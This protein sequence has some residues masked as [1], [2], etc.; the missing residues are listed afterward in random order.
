MMAR[1]EPGYEPVRRERK[2]AP[3]DYQQGRALLKGNEIV[4]TSGDCTMGRNTRL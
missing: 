4:W 2:T 1:F 3:T